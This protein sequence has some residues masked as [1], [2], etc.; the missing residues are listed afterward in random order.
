MLEIIYE[1]IHESDNVTVNI[2]LNNRTYRLMHYWN[3]SFSQK[4]MRYKENLSAI[5]FLHRVL[6]GA[7]V[8]WEQISCIP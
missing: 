2:I 4:R 3:S 8:E 7:E 6:T 5:S 1:V